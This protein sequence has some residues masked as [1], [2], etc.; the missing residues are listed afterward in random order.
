[1]D[2]KSDHRNRLLILFLLVLLFFSFAGF[3]FAQSGY[4]FDKNK[5]ILDGGLR[6]FKSTTEIEK[7]SVDRYQVIVRLHS[8]APSLPPEFSLSFKFPKN[9]INQLWNSQTWSNK[10][11]F[12]LPAYDRAAANFSIIS[13]L[14]LNDQNQ[15]TFTCDDRFDSRFIS[16]F[17]KEQDDTLVF[18]LGFFED[19]PP[20]SNMQDYEVHI[21]VDFRNIH[22]SEAIYE[23]SKWR[24]Q[25]LFNQAAMDFKH[26]D[27]PVFSTWYPMHRNI[28]FENITRELDSLKTFGFKSILM[29]DEWRSL[30]KMKVD[31]IYTYEENSFETLQIFDK[32][33]KDMGLKLFMWYS[34]PFM[35][36][37]PVIAKR[38][39]GKYLRYKAPRQIYVLDPRYPEVRQY[40]ISTYYNFYKG[41]QF[42]GFWFDFMNDFYPQES[43]TVSDDLGRDFV[44]VQL[45]VDSLMS[46]MNR[47]L[48]SI[49]PTIFMGQDFTPVGPDQNNYQNF[50]AGFVGVNSTKLIREKMVNNRLLYGRYTPFME[51]MGVHPRDKSEEVA[52]KFQSILFGNPYLSFF[53]TTLPEDTKQTIRFWLNY[54]KENRHVLMESEFEPQKVSN[55]YPIIKVQNKEKI[56]YALYSDFTLNLPLIVDRTIDIINSKETTLLNFTVSDQ[57][58]T[59][60]YEIYNHM[61]VLTQHDEL[62]TKRKNTVEFEVPEGGFLRI[63]P[64]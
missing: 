44:D 48:R 3:S 31:T 57:G 16:T 36:G 10:S 7:I 8:S 28:P 11:F 37:N 56:I 43:V 54:W 53:T 14:T 62:K 59:Y 55:Q 42:D 4:Q 12:S 6:P 38:F 30:V 60:N 19:N 24:F 5:I 40:L 50:L 15:I 45:A 13:G 34:L 35:G 1:M 52:R 17:V 26:T 23:A 39:E 41:W 9:K 33:R 32:K 25:E 63:L 51:I 22:F 27:L 29:D 58:A 61:G 49:D 46:G 2:N 64:N 20:L 47:R 21:L 18:G